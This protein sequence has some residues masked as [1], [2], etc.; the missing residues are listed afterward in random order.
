MAVGKITL[1]AERLRATL[2]AAPWPHFGDDEIA[3]VERVLR[4]GKVNYWTGEQNS[5]FEAEF[6]AQF[7]APHAIALGNGTLALDL[8]MIALG[9]GAGDE[10]VVTPRSYFASTSSVVLAG[11][12]PVFADVDPDSQNITAES[13]AR[14]MTPRTRA[15]MPVHLA[16]WPCEMAKIMALA[17]DHGVAVIEDCAQAHGAMVDGRVVG[18]FGDVAAFSF[19]QDKIMTT[20]GEGGMFLTQSRSICEAA[21]AFKDHGKS[22][23]AMARTD[24]PP[25]FRWLHDSIGSNYRMTEM[26]AAIGRVQLT[27]LQGWLEAR[28]RNAAIYQDILGSLPALRAPVPAATVQHAYYKFYAFVRP[29]AL[30]RGWDRDRILTA[31]SARGVPG[32]SGSCPEIYREKAIIERGLAPPAPLPV[33]RQLGR[34][35]LMFM[36]HPTLEPEH[37]ARIAEVIREVIT[38]ATRR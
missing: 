18:S 7:G 6:A 4:S 15:I 5:Q 23:T 16:G 11:A 25:G 28:R 12:T 36:V 38:L 21:W 33:A 29:E 37:I 30:K 9:I 10:V 26:Q 32:L 17:A 27:K 1:Q 22:R 20:G 31:L 14:V 3:A 13:I 34:T 24:H 8:A 2:V 35:S 19:C